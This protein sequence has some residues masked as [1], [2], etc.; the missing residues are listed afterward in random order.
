M[1][2]PEKHLDEI[3]TTVL[4]Q[5][6]ILE[7]TKEEKEE[8]YCALRKALSSIVILLSP[9]SASSLCKLLDVKKEDLDQT[10]NDMHS[11]LEIPKDRFQPLR[12]HHPSFRDYLLSKSRCQDPNFWV[13]E[14]QAHQVLADNCLRLMS[15]SLKQ[16]ICGLNAPGKLIAEV[17]RSR[18]DRNLPPEV[19]YAC[20]YWIEHVQKSSAQLC[21]DDQ[22]HHFLQKHLLHWFEALGWMG[23]MSE[24]VY[25]IAALQSFATVSISSTAYTLAE[26]SVSQTIALIF[27]ISSMTQ[28]DLFSIID[29]LLSRL[30]FRL[31]AVPLYSYLQQVW[32]ESSSQTVRLNG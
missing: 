28:S 3:Y 32:L 6:I 24:G 13:N 30:Q 1:I 14:K 4:K 25:A 12:L 22:V 20:L 21:D 19:Q 26:H 16:D 18:I 10:L 2:A 9:L 17:D 7:F 27:Q 31:T 23:K 11:V 5:S 15:I 8:V 29:Q